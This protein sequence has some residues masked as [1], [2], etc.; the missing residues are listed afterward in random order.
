MTKRMPLSV[1]SFEN[2]RYVVIGLV[3]LVATTVV[4][5]KA[6]NANCGSS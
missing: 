6:R 2:R 1:P 3:Q 5:L 4:T